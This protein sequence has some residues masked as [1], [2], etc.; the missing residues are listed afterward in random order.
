[1]TV[2]EE[3]LRRPASVFQKIHDPGSRERLPAILASTKGKQRTT[4]VVPFVPKRKQ[5]MARA[6]PLGT[7]ILI[8]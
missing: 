6:A 7:E 3:W 5:H 8:E 1:M 4:S 2:R